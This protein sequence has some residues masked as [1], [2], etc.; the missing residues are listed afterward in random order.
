VD[1]EPAQTTQLFTTMISTAFVESD[2]NKILDAGIASLDKTSTI[3]K[4]INDVKNWHKT[5]PENWKETRRLLRE[6][7]TQEEGRKEHH[8]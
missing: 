7:Y 1:G 4:V 5:F 6:K 2:I 3:L 8:P